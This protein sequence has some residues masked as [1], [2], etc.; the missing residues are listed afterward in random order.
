MTIEQI[1]DALAM[2]NEATAEIDDGTY[3]V[4]NTGPQSQVVI[5]G[6]GPEGDLCYGVLDPADVRFI[7]LA[8]TLLPQALRELRE[9]MQDTERL[10]WLMR[11]GCWINDRGERHKQLIRY[12]CR[13]VDDNTCAY[14]DTPRAAIDAAMGS[15]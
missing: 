3:I 5:R 12:E 7:S 13:D 11:T 6:G 9:K 1:D 8:R 14:G 2:C 15:K 4:N 10:E